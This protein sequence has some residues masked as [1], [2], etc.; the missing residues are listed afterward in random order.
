MKK[1]FAIIICLS[2]LS[3]TACTQGDYSNAARCSD[4][5]DSV[6][7][8]LSDGQEY[9]NYDSSHIKYNFE[10][11]SLQD[12]ACIFYS[13]DSSDINEVGIFHGAKEDD[14]D[15]LTA[16]IE[17]YL[18]DMRENQRA[19]I[20]SYAPNEIPKLEDA[21]VYIFGNYIVYT[22][23]PSDQRDAAIDEIEKILL[24]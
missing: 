22:I 16:I 17:N 21:R 19:F 12:D 15:E 24:K 18:R 2:M 4:I 5:A 13:V 6:K 8:S 7:L 3:L 23:L 10:D 9:E 14:I 20:E 11:T 1:I